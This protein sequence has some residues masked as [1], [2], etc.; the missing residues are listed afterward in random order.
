MIDFQSYEMLQTL[1]K[2]GDKRLIEAWL[3]LTQ[4]QRE[5]FFKVD[6]EYKKSCKESK[7]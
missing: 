3:A 7:K 6:A 2:E 1:Q 4:E 5:L